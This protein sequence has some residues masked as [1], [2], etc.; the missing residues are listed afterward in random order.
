MRH[1]TALLLL[2]LTAA[3]ATLLSQFPASSTQQELK[4]QATVIDGD[5]IEIHG[6]RLRLRG[7]DSPES[8]Q[9]C[10]DAA[11]KRY[12][13]GQAASFA[14]ADFVG[15]ST[16]TCSA[17]TDGSGHAERSYDRVIATCHAQG[18]DLGSWLV[19]S[20]WAVPYWK[21]GGSRYRSEYT[22]AQETKSGIW[23][24][25]FE[26]PASYRAKTRR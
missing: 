14:L 13:C 10:S 4:G 23:S 15:R 21:Y 26:E 22:R 7:I 17:E 12:R 11:G 8:S 5:T 18:Q 24:G 20:G 19:E 16:V 25:Q 1:G 2:A 6:T 3:S 9:L